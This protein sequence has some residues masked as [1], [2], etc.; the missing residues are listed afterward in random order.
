MG[1]TLGLVSD[2]TIVGFLVDI[3][4][5]AASMAAPLPFEAGAAVEIVGACVTPASVLGFFGTLGFAIL[6]TP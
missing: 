2:F 1:T 6:F 5:A 4:G 3:V